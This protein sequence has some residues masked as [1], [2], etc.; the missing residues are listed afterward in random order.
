MFTRNDSIELSWKLI[1]PILKGWEASQEPP[2]E[3]YEPGS[4]GPDQADSLLGREGRCWLQG[5]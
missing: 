5:C 4:W 1:D 2:L 3:V